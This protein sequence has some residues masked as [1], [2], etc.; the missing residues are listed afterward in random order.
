MMAPTDLGFLGGG[1]GVL[2][3]RGRLDRY[4]WELCRAELFSDGCGGD[5]AG[6]LGPVVETGDLTY[7][8]F[9][10]QKTCNFVH[11]RLLQRWHT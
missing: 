9:L 2:T 1:S 11:K 4:R 3:N 7:T 6:I 10:A 8:F 5:V